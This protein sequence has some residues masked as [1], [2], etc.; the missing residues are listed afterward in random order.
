MLMEGGMS[1]GW[2]GQLDMAAGIVRQFELTSLNPAVQACEALSCDD[3][4]LDVAVLGQFK[5][6]KSSLL[7]AVLGETIFPVGVVPVTAVITRATA[8]T[9]YILRVTYPDGSIEEDNPDRI[10]EFVTEAG[11]PGNRR[12]VAVVDVFT[13]AMASWAGLR[14]V[15]TPGLGSV[16]VHNSEA[17]RFWMP[18]IA[19]ALVTVSAERPL[20][21]EDRRLVA[22]A[23]ETAPRVVVVLT[24]VDLLTKAE[25]EEVSAFLDRALRES[26]E[27]I[28]PVLPFSSRVEPGQYVHR[29]HQ[30][31]FLP[32]IRDVAGERRAARDVKLAALVRA[33]R[34]YLVVGCQ[35]AEQ[36]DVDRQRL[37]AAVLDES[38][39]AT[40]IRDELRLAGQ[41]VCEEARPKFEKLLLAQQAAVE[42]RVTAA[43]AETLPRWRGNLAEQ[44]QR[45]ETWMAERL[46][47]GLTPLSLEATPMAAELLGQAERRLRRVVEAFRDR[48][49]RNIRE[50]TGI[51]ISSATWEV[52]RPQVAVVRVSIGRAFMTDWSLLWWLLPMRLVGG[53]FRRHALGRVA[54]EVEKNLRRLAG[55][56][57]EA[58]EKAVDDLRS[59]AAAWTDA[60][61][62]T[63]DRLLRQQ[64]AEATAFHEALRRLE[65]ANTSQTA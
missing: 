59:H 4:P 18:N 25:L 58:V 60:E 19:M 8:G 47:D 15:D 23:R 55:D 35:A 3:T 54:W 65:E 37:R 41:R 49:G 56:W 42:Q 16:F 21:D 9:E 43:L 36:A 32:V 44:A 53:L 61:L 24:K 2:N 20:S 63:L 7:N 38:V 13:P 11:N 12:R 40:V 29:L 30:A 27:I 45:Y 48:L 26:F 64:P 6:G 22:E 10:G 57:K 46:T 14:L 52:K 62:A 17:T 34:G 39:S 31:V 50:A 51:T 1:A 28:P 33:C 5:S